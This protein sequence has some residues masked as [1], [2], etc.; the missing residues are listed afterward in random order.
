M[1]SSSE[2]QVAYQNLF[3]QLRNYIWDVDTVENIADLEVAI[4]DAFPN[5]DVMRQKFNRLRCDIN[6]AN[7]DDEELKKAIDSLDSLL[8][9]DDTLYVDLYKVQEV[10]HNEDSEEINSSG[11]GHSR[12]FSYSGGDND[13][14]R[15]IRERD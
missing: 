4:Y 7:V 6:Y 8:Q 11:S 15:E 1:I 10:P 13:I 2:F 5:R 14:N 3:K 9:A 12:A